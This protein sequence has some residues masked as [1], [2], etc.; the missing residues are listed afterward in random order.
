MIKHMIIK[1][2]AGNDFI[3]GSL[4]RKCMEIDPANK[5]ARPEAATGFKTGYQIATS[6]IIAKTTFKV[7]IT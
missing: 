2:A 4:I 5:R 7:P 3:N 6:S 1:S